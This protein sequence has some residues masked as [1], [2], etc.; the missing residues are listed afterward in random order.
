M[1]RPKHSPGQVCE[2]KSVV[3]LLQIA[4][5]FILATPIPSRFI[6]VLKPPPLSEMERKMN[7]FFCER[8]IVTS[9]ALH[10]LK[11]SQLTIAI[12]NK[13]LQ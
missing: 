10:V 2:I 1:S 3:P 5:L 7:L 6:L 11:Y 9:F 4:L 8:L 13:I 12:V